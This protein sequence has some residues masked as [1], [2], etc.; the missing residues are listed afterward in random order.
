M[1]VGLLLQLV[2]P[3][4]LF[5]S[6]NMLFIRVVTLN[7]ARGKDGEAFCSSAFGLDFR[8]GDFNFP[9]MLRR[10]A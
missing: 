7:L 8:H 5:L 1:N 10:N 2:L 3:S 4:S 9:I 6:Q